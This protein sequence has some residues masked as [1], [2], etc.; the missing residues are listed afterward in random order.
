MT[1]LVILLP[2][3]FCTVACTSQQAKETQTLTIAREQIAAGNSAA[4]LT[5]LLEAESRSPGS[6]LSGE[7]ALEIGRLYRAQGRYDLAR[8]YLLKSFSAGFIDLATFRTET[9]ATPTRSLSIPLS[10][11]EYNFRKQQL[12]AERAYF[13]RALRITLG[14]A[15]V[16]LL[17]LVFAFV[18]SRRRRR[19]ET[20]R[21][22]ALIDNLS[23]STTSLL[24]ELDDRRAQEIR[25]KRLLANRFSEVRELTDTIYCYEHNPALLHRKLREVLSLRTV[26]S[27]LFKDLEEVVDAYRNHL[28]HRLRQQYAALTENELQFCSLLAAGFS[29]QEICILLNIQSVQ[30]VWMKKY[31]LRCKL[32]LPPGSDVEDFLRDFAAVE[33]QQSDEMINNNDNQRDET[34]R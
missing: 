1:K 34:Y 12:A 5:L 8:N 31:R 30:N 24:S 27:A 17:S 23:H 11:T 15:G 29:V 4:A 22:L 32:G 25:L 6:R 2:F 19:E 3:L 21:L 16:L 26:D 28:I 13:Q 33:S 10:E 20:D 14:C 9:S 18:R 7:S